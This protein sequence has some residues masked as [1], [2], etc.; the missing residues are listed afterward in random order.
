[1]VQNESY[2]A[3]APIGGHT[4]N[5]TLGRVEGY[6]MALEVLMQMTQK[7]PK[8]APQIDP[9]YEAETPEEQ[10]QRKADVYD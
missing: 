2:V 7:I 6:A 10:K 9:T 3:M 1:M 5:R 8:A 4:E